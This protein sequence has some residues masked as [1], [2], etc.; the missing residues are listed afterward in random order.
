[1]C[2]QSHDDDHCFRR[3]VQPKEDRAFRGA[4]GLMA[5][6]TDEPPVLA[7]MDTNIALTDLASRM[8]IPLGAEYGGWVHRPP[9]RFAGKRCQKEYVGRPISF[10]S[11]P[12]HGLVQSY[13]REEL[14]KELTYFS[15]PTLAHAL[16]SVSTR[17][18]A[19]WQ[20][21]GRSGV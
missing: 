18:P 4:E 20:W 16:C 11:L 9:S 21:S 17:Q 2:E 12:H 15:Q 8:A 3:G 6:L 13:Q 19:H 14:E 7:R 5:L 10:A 1:V